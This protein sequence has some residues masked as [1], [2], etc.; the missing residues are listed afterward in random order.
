MADATDAASIS[1]VSAKVTSSV[2]AAFDQYRASST[3][4][5]VLSITAI[6]VTILAVAAAAVYFL[7]YADNVL[8][9]WAEKYYKAKAK[10]EGKVLENTES[11]KAEGFLKGQWLC[12]RIW[13]QM[14]CISN[15]GVTR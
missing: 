15:G 5:A 6:I 8:E 10:E 13:S 7:G 14:C 11:E 4:T 2:A 3:T 9:W 1:S 12:S